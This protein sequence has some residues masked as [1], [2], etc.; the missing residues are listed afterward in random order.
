MKKLASI[1]LT[2]ESLFISCYQKIVNIL[3]MIRPFLNINNVWMS[4][5][6]LNPTMQILMTILRRISL[7]L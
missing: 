7:N 5:D 6:E 1:S 4:M 3:L 2:W